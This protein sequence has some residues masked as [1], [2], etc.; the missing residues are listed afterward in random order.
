M[1]EHW[2]ATRPKRSLTSVPEVLTAIITAAEGGI[3]D[4]DSQIRAEDLL[5]KLKLKRDG[6]L[7]DREN[8]GG[9][10]GRTYM[11]WMTSLGLMMRYEDRTGS[12]LVVPTLAGEEVIRT[13]DP[14]SL[15]TN[16]V[17]RYQ[18]PSAY[19]SAGRQAVSARFRV[20]PLLFLL[21]L[22]TEEGL[23]G[24]ITENEIADIVIF[25]GE[26]ESEET[27]NDVVAEI[28]KMRASGESDRPLQ[29]YTDIANT[30]V[31]WLSYT[32]LIER[33]EGKISILPN[34]RA[35]VESILER[36]FGNIN[37]FIKQNP[38]AHINFQRS[39]GLPPGKVKDTRDLSSSITITPREINERKVLGV[40]A[41]LSI[42]KLIAKITPE[43]IGITAELSGVPSEET[44]AILMRIY[45]HGAV[46]AFMSGYF[47]MAQASRERATEFEKTTAEIFRNVFGFEAEHIGQRGN[48][49][50]VLIRNSD[51]CAII[52]NKAYKDG[53]SIS[54]DHKRRM[55]DLYINDYRRY[56]GSPVLD[57]AFFSYLSLSFG[58]NIK[59]QIEEIAERTGLSGSAMPVSTFIRMVENQTRNTRIYSYDDIR[60]IFSLNR[61]VL[62][63]DVS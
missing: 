41:R 47:E 43:I 9:G 16:Q 33:H 60:N 6:D 36:R 38:K 37:T 32:Q 58:K 11:A 7:R 53:Y 15:L 13:D 45:P 50:D 23:D 34:K 8:R 51:W 17:L 22:M 42:E 24:Y 57:L 59:S 12:N 54:G 31:N 40:F 63:A 52:D 25:K 48:V 30:F 49:P 19:T 5:A 3:W 21:R 44:E 55:I 27:V 29:K 46:G 26:N 1:L 18:F 2:W 56:S 35:E 14:V 4:L 39:Y 20:R 28:Q 62:L 61:E 10:G